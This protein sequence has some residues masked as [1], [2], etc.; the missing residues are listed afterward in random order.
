MKLSEFFTD[1]SLGEL[2]QLSVGTEN[3]GNIAESEYPKIIRFLQKALT[4]LYTRFPLRFEEVIIEQVTGRTRYP[5]DS[6]Y[7]TTNIDNDEVDHY[8]VDSV[9]APFLDNILQIEEVYSELGE[10]V[11]VNNRESDQSIF[12]VDYKTLLIPEEFL[13][14]SALSVTYK[15]NHPVIK[16]SGIIDADNIELEIHE[17]LLE[18]LLTMVTAMVFKSTGSPENTQLALQMDVTADMQMSV[19][20]SKNLIRKEEFVNER[21][22]RNGWV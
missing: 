4:R 21:F 17:L 18:P 10:I 8:L 16:N 20:E 19:I 1:L 7:A 6:K 5:L 22:W 9:D 15:A 11:A 13:G 3:S 14:G 2:S 12:T